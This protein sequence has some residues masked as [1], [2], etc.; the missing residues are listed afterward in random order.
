MVYVDT[1]IP[2]L[3]NYNQ[4][5]R[6]IRLQSEYTISSKPGNKHVNLGCPK[7]HVLYNIYI[8]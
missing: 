2:Q 1:N 8:E 4:A 3:Y 7:L 6:L 5:K